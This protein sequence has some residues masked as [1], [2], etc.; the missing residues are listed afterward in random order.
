MS[1]FAE[2]RYLDEHEPRP[3]QLAH[4][5]NA[6]LR[7]VDDA[8]IAYRARDNWGDLPTEIVNDR[9]RRLGWP[10]RLT[11]AGAAAWGWHIR[12]DRAAY[13]PDHAAAW[14]RPR[15]ALAGAAGGKPYRGILWRYDLNSAYPAT[16]MS[17]PIP[18]WRR[19]RLCVSRAETE[20]ALARGEI[21]VVRASVRD[22]PPGL[23]CVTRWP[24]GDAD[25][26]DAILTSVDVAA[27]REAGARVAVHAGVL[28][29]GRS[30]DWY[31]A[32]GE[33][34]LALRRDDPA[35]GPL[36][37]LA[38]NGLVG[39]L[40]SDGHYELALRGNGETG[41]VRGR[42]ITTHRVFYHS[43]VRPRSWI[44]AALVIATVRVRVWK[45]ARDYDAAW[46]WID[47]IAAPQP[48]PDELVGSAPGMWRLER[49]GES[50]IL[51]WR[52]GIVA[53]ERCMAVVPAPEAQ[54]LVDA[55]AD[56]A[57]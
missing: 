23:L 12:D 3:G 8:R 26:N 54:R 36:Y 43:R 19:E 11:P 51:D 46:H 30:W 37:K 33:R 21:G 7:G 5:V 28:A 34:L 18:D 50:R 45:L 2:F 44:V 27:L 57:E 25:A 40:A 10:T 49:V 55:A 38:A 39:R 29:P 56:S 32:V 13:D 9:L 15:F 20:R 17:I 1:F 47:A 24:H 42:S 41:V 16:A 6:R 52:G 31:R 22:A 14:P 53:G 48:L 4:L 35:A